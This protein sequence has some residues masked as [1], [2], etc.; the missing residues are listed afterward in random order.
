M[1]CA[2]LSCV[3]EVE[4]MIILRHGVFSAVHDTIVQA[5]SNFM[6]VDFDALI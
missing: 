6:I 3:L 4:T 1:V 2:T 5:S